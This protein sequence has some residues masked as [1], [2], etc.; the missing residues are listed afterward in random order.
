MSAKGV[1][2]VKA[3]TAALELELVLTDVLGVV[4]VV[5][6]ASV[7]LCGMQPNVGV[8]LAIDMSEMLINMH[9]V[10]IPVHSK[11]PPCTYP[12]ITH[13]ACLTNCDLYSHDKLSNYKR[14]AA[15]GVMTFILH[16]D[17]CM[18]CPRL[19]FSCYCLPGPAPHAR[20]AI[21]APVA[22]L[23]HC[24]FL[25]ACLSLQVTPRLTTPYIHPS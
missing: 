15:R 1:S 17:G 23:S 9:Y 7:V 2:G 25:L 24:Y 5:T 22:A 4:N 8:E 20:R 3:I 13:G 11:P 6:P 10:S 19:A 18:S 12:Q 14:T 21:L 16:V